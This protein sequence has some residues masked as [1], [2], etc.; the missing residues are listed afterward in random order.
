M[1]QLP[2]LEAALPTG[3]ATHFDSYE[4]CDELCRNRRIARLSSPA[5]EP[6]A[7]PKAYGLAQRQVAFHRNHLCPAPRGR[8]HFLG[9]DGALHSIVPSGTGLEVVTGPCLH[10][11]AAP[12]APRA[13]MVIA[14]HLSGPGAHLL[15]LS[16]GS[17]DGRLRLWVCGQDGA[18]T[19][20]ADLDWTSAGP[21]LAAA[22]PAADWVQAAHDLEHTSAG[23]VEIAEG[24]VGVTRA[25]LWPRV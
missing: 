25:R 3:R 8:C 5:L 11:L 4:R 14:V 13:A 10:G 20:T 16:S 18:P 9:R 23:T 2:P 6:T 1:A 24:G 19:A 15:A 22:G 7:E 21:L 12:D 17:A